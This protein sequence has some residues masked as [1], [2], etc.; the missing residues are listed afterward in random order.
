MFPNCILIFFFS[1]MM[2]DENETLVDSLEMKESK[3]EVTT[4]KVE[5]VI[6]TTHEEIIQE[7]TVEEKVTLVEE[8]IN[9]EPIAAP[10]WTYA[11]G[12]HNL[13]DI[14]KAPFSRK[15]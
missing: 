11:L 3:I 10:S 4:T 14:L 5:T 12:L 7:D 2:V 9:V 13:L 8:S 15:K 1:D 6:T